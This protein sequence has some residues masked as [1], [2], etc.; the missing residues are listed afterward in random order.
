MNRSTINWGIGQLWTW[1]PI[2]GCRRGCPYCYARGIH[3]HYVKP[4]TGENFSEIIFHADRLSD[5]DLE[6]SSRI[7]FLGSVSDPEYY[8]ALRFQQIIYQ[9]QI[10][11]QHTFMFLSK[12]PASYRNFVFP[13]N[14]VLGLTI[15]KLENIATFQ[16]VEEIAE[17]ERVFLS[18][19]PLLGM[20][21]TPLPDTLE[22]V[23]CGAMSGP[24]AIVP[25]AEWVESVK[26]NA[27]EGKLFFKPHKKLGNDWWK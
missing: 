27:P 25:K 16:Q 7:I 12:N 21:D 9:C 18:I 24:G 15:T 26:R 4:K 23:I 17:H 6:K 11:K 19:E 13:D 2:S 3:D 22:R 1:N 8:P 14:C 20:I 10:H 5:P